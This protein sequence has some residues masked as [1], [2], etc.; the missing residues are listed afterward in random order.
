VGFFSLCHTS[1]YSC[2]AN[3]Q[4]SET[5]FCPKAFQVDFL[6]VALSNSEVP[7]CH[8]ELKLINRLLM[9][10]CDTFSNRFAKYQTSKKLP[11]KDLQLW[12]IE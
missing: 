12:G 1:S 2:F 5:H 6:L 3:I 11:V 10:A 9:Q 4:I 8:L 7:H